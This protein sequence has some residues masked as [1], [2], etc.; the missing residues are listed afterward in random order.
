MILFI[1]SCVREGS[2][3]KKLADSLLEKLNEDYVELKL[4]EID[5]PK[6]DEDFINK[7]S[8]LTAKGAFSDPMFE[9]ARQ[10]A[11]ADKIVIAAPYW[12]LSFPASLKQYLE[13]INVVGITF[14]YTDDGFPVGLCRADSLYYVTTAGGSYVPFEYGFGYVKSLAE[15]LYGIKNVRLLKAA[16]LDIAG[17]DPEAIM[18][19]AINNEIPKVL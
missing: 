8:A 16:G 3:T 9:L 5:F 14:K 6:A 19:N 2:R 18:Q 13:I 15:A 10:F 4:E 11:E 17:A 7:R 12:D 1:N